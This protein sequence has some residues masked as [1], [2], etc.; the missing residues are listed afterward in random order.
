MHI[1]AILTSITLCTLLAACSSAQI[2]SDLAQANK[3]QSQVANACA[4]ASASAN[5]PGALLLQASVPA[6]AQ[7]VKLIQASCGTEQAVASLVLS[8]TSVA[9]LGTLITTIQS[10]GKT[11]LPPPVDPTAK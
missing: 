9:W 7:A 2:A 1:N 5:D 10:G 4:I 8:P 11:V 3:Y 6:V